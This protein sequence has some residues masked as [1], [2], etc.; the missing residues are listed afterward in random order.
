MYVFNSLIVQLVKIDKEKLNREEE[1]KKVD[2]LFIC[3][4]GLKLIVFRRLIS[5][6]RT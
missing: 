6:L 2:S 5:L 1:E 4:V 3:L